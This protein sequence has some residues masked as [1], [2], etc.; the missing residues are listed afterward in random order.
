MRTVVIIQARMGSSRL[1]G[2]VLIRLGRKSVLEHVIR[3]VA[4]C[5][6]VSDVVVATTTVERDDPVV[7]EAE[8]CGAKVYRGSED[9]VLRRY[10]EAADRFDADTV[11]RVT[12]DCPLLDSDLLTKMLQEFIARRGRG[13]KID[14]FSNTLTRTFP[15]GLDIEIFGKSVLDTACHEAVKPHE[16]EHV[17]PFIYQ[18][19]EKFVVRNYTG[20]KDR[21]EYRLTLDTPDDLS[22]LSAIFHELGDEMETAGTERVIDLLERRPD[23]ASLNAGV[24]QKEIGR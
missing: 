4:A 11:V 23:L 17:T 14:Y 8:R 1:P 9:N 13:E 21:S 22:L 20:E 3:R 12:S 5:P 10:C 2:K 19:P 24:E 15:R 7:N 18:H 16:L 6:L